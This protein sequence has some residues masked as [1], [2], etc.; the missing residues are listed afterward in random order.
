M[1]EMLGPSTSIPRWRAAMPS[2]LPTISKIADQVHPSLPEAPSI[3]AERHR[4][5]PTG[6]RLLERDGEALGYLIS[7]PWRANIVPRLNSLLHDIPSG[8]DTFYLHDLALLPTARGAGAARVIVE[9]MADQARATGFPS[10]S[11]VAVNW[12][13]PFWEHLGFRSMDVPAL[14]DKLGSYDEGARFM[15]RKL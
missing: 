1:K 4:L 13:A 5:F 9:E 10:M 8:A 14:A 6:I 7:H 12:S 11:L 3:F 2:D 15:V